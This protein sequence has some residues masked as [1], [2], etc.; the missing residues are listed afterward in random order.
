MAAAEGHVGDV[1]LRFAED[2]ADRSDHARG[3]G[4]FKDEEIAL[5][6]RVEIVIVDAHDAGLATEEGSRNGDLLLLVP[7]GD[8]DEVGEL[9]LL[10]GTALGNA[11]A[12]AFSEGG[13]VE[14]VRRARGR[15]G[16]KESLE[17]R[18][19]HEGRVDLGDLAGV[20]DAEEVRLLRCDLADQLAEHFGESEVGADELQGRLVEIRHVHRVDDFTT[21][22]ASGDGLGDLDAD[23]F[24]SFLG[25][26][27]EVR[28]EDH[29]GTAEEF[30]IGRGR[31]DF[32]NVEGRSGD[33][34]RLEPL[35]EGGFVDQSA[36]RAV[37]DAHAGFH[38]FDPRRVHEM[39]GLGR[40]RHVQ[41]D[42]VGLGNGFLD[43]LAELNTHRLGLARGEVGIVGDHTHAEA[44]RAL[45]EFGA[46]A[47]HAENG[48]GLVVELDA[49]IGLA[50][51]LEA[52]LDDRLVALGD[53]AGERHHQG[54]GVLGRGNGVTAGRV[55]HDDAVFGGDGDVDVVDP[56]P[57]ASDG[58]EDA[59]T[60]F[61]DGA[62]DLHARAHDDAFVV[63]CVFDE[64][65]LAEPEFDVDDEA[66]RLEKLNAF[67]GNRIADEDAALA[68]GRGDKFG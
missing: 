2:A 54:E 68:H 34:A 25:R 7:G 49:G 43:G 50:S 66:G 42:E 67:I 57:G 31:L 14:V 35:E 37:D 16:L 56:D 47:A 15:A 24:L 39:F 23:V 40:H 60:G 18:A 6:H 20:F 38:D 17:G 53:V 27:A 45:R 44:H 36:A 5:G 28:G 3:V 64:F 32:E 41:G 19:G 62:G 51:F 52:S 12:S 21:E 1:D 58:A 10:G 9:T 30:V 61:D 65:G 46:D 22:E 29:L 8:S 33:L 4:V 63:R 11:D 59:G 13:G 55:H 48:E 26:G